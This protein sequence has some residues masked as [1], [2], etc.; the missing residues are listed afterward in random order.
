MVAVGNSTE[1]ALL[2]V[3][4]RGAASDY[5]EAPRPQ[6]PVALPGP[7]LVRPQADDD[8]RRATATGWSSLVKGAPEMRA[9]AVRRT[10]SPP[11]AAVAAVDA[12]RADGGRR[13]SSR[14]AAGAGD[15][16]ARVRPRASCRPTRP[17]DEDA[18]HDRRDELERGL[19]FAGFVA[20]RDPLRDDVKDA[21]AECRAAGHRGE[22]DHRRQRRD[23]PGHRPRDRPARPRRTRSS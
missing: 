18:L 9:G 20:I 23:G 3:A 2:H 17:H 14:D 6:F 1:G 12:G 7:L 16:D 22:D 10:T 13:R 15:A 4:A 8:G 19:V 5:V 11:T 21:V